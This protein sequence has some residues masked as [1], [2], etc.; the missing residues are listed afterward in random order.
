MA[1]PLADLAERKAQ[2]KRVLRR[3]KADYPEVECALAHD[4][5]EQLLVATILS[6]QCTDARVNIV[7]KELFA[8]H[9]TPAD[10]AKLPIARLEGFV[11]STGFFRNKAKN[12]K[13]C[14]IELVEK[15]GGEVPQDMDTLVGLAGVGR[16]TA[17]VVLGTAFGLATGVVVDTHVG[18]LSRRTGLTAEKDPVKVERGLMEILPRKEWVDFS[19]RMIYHGRQICDARRPKCDECSMRKFCPQIGV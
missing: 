1:K 13:A 11:K 4:S 14:C 15:H 17:N 16:K 8:K 18:R 2:S 12:I 6:A 9:P 10:L 3:L 19:H 5:P 7:T